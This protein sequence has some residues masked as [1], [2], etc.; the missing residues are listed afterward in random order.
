MQ[1]QGGWVATFV[2]VGVL[3]GA[4]LLGGVYFIKSQQ[5]ANGSNA[6]AGTSK[7]EATPKESDKQDEAAKNETEPKNETQK[8]E[9]RQPSS[10]PAATEEDTEETA[11]PPTGVTSEDNE[12]PVTGPAET[13]GTLIIFGLLTF[14]IASYFQSRR[15]RASL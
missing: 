9:E 14:V 3:L 12:L 4:G 15:A 1:H 13:L 7:E 5:T 11:V 10:Q 6:P 8:Q 2:I